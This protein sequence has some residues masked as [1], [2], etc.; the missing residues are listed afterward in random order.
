MTVQSKP[1]PRPP[2]QALS[3]TAPKNSRNR[4]CTDTAC[5]SIERAKVTAVTKMA[6]PY[7]TNQESGLRFALR[8]CI[9]GLEVSISALIIHSTNLL[10]GWLFV[11]CF[12]LEDRPAV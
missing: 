1:G 4:F 3:A 10:N 5:N 8:L 2:N 6:N 7:R 12:K 11:V 9:P